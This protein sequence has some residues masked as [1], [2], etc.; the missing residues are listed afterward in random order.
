[1]MMKIKM[2]LIPKLLTIEEPEIWYDSGHGRFIYQYVLQDCLNFCD[3]TDEESADIIK[4]ISAINRQEE[5]LEICIYYMEQLERLFD[6]H[7]NHNGLYLGFNP[8]WADYGIYNFYK[9]D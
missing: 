7:L 5:N 3:L 2:E 9:E 4:Q 1:M 8:D 6:E